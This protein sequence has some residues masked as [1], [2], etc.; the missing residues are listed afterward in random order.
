MNKLTLFVLVLAFSG[1]G[2]AGF[3]QI[4]DNVNLEWSDNNFQATDIAVGNIDSDPALEAVVVGS[5]GPMWDEMGIAIFEIGNAGITF[6][7]KLYEPVV[8]PYTQVTP[9]SVVLCDVDGDGTKDIVVGGYRKTMMMISYGF[10]YTYDYDGTAISSQ[11]DYHWSSPI[12]IEDVGAKAGAGHCNVHVAGGFNAPGTEYEYTAIL[13]IDSGPFDIYQEENK[14]WL[15]DSRAYAIDFFQNGTVV[16]GG[17]AESGWLGTQYMSLTKNP[18]NYTTLIGSMTTNREATSIVVDD[19]ANTSAEEVIAGADMT[20]LMSTYAYLYLLDQDFNIID[21]VSVLPP[22]GSMFFYDAYMNDVETCDVDNDGSKEI[23]GAMDFDVSN[24]YG[25]LNGYNAIEIFSSIS[26]LQVTEYDT[27]TMGTGYESG[28]EAIDCANT[29]ADANQELV[30]VI[31][32]ADSMTNDYKI[33]VAVLENEPIVPVINVVAPLP[34]DVISGGYT[35]VINVS[36]DSAPADILAQYRFTGPNLTGYFMAMNNTGYQFYAPVNFSAFADG[37]YMVHFKATDGDGNIM[38]ETVDIMVDNSILTVNMDNPAQ[39]S[40]VQPGTLIAFSASQ[41]LASFVYSLDNGVTNNTL[42]APYRIDTAG[43]HDGI[44]KIHVW[45]ESTTGNKFHG[46]FTV[47]I[48]GTS[49]EIN[50]VHPTAFEINAGDEI[51][52]IVKDYQLGV[53]TLVM[54]SVS[55]DYTGSPMPII[56]YTETWAGENTVEVLARD[57]A[58][59]PVSTETYV[60]HVA[61]TELP[62]EN[63]T[64]TPAPQDIANQ[65]LELIKTVE[66]EI[67]DAKAAGEETAL[68][69]KILA[70]A[71]RLF[72]L[73]KY[74][75]AEGVAN[76]AR[77]SIGKSMPGEAPPEEPPEVPPEQPPEQPPAEPPEE[78]S[79]PPAQP[80]DYTLIGGVILLLAVLAAAYYLLTRKKKPKATK[81]KMAAKKKVKEEFKEEATEKIPEETVSEEVVEEVVEEVP[82]EPEEMPVAEETAPP[83]EKK[84]KKKAKKRRRKKKK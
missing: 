14:A 30:S 34:G 61:E 47:V 9:T 27:Q 70:N 5:A 26:L 63:V 60:F 15:T 2:F 8:S 83:K 64:E 37:H 4:T 13:N 69:E 49:P 38:E 67:H 53:L 40:V 36:D 48:D 41:P 56:V 23:F 11:Y 3:C 76:D 79:A 21:Y 29:D 55:V 10:V 75:Q 31:N 6:E 19:V 12:I 81:E 42:T 71:K 78:P 73:G 50:L 52:I 18:G 74:Q 68:A 51:A 66:Q 43:W 35:L 84:P 54:N 24:D 72:S 44:K 7:D 1:I 33:V 39:G 45:A 57:A 16:T 25:K 58:G 46:L 80:L 82:E 32:L 28:I 62:E 20:S 22:N 77:D 65:T 59:N 17:T